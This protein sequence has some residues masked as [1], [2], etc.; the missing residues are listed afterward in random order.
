MD[1]GGG[2][3]KIYKNLCIMS[4]KDLIVKSVGII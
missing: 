4:F 3:D 2:G 1:K